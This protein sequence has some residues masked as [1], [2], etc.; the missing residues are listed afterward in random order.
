MEN[1]LLIGGGGHCKSVI[2]VI[3][4]ENKYSIA[5][6]IDKKERIGEKVLGYEIMGSDEDIKKLFDKYKYA[7]ITIGHIKSNSTRLSIFSLLKSI[8][9]KIPA[10]ISPL[11]YVSKHSFIGEGS[12]IMHHALVNTGAKIG[13]NCIINTKA[14]IEHDVLIEDNCH[15]STASVVNGGTI[16]KENTF[17]GSNSTSKE[18]IQIDGFIKAGSINR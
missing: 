1:I 12:I 18:Y 17:I 13:Q 6:I 3:E 4:Q 11:A 7:F 5:G 8:G 2:D 16:V 15:I 10:I 14:L 9:Y